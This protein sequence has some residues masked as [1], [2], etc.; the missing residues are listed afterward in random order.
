MRIIFLMIMFLIQFDCMAVERKSAQDDFTPLIFSCLNAYAKSGDVKDI[1][2][3]DR[4]YVVYVDNGKLID[5]FFS[6]GDVVEGEG[7]GD[8]KG[9]LSCSG[10]L[11]DGF[12][13]YRLRNPYVSDYFIDK[14]SVGNGVVNVDTCGA[15]KERMYIFESGKIFYQGEKIFEC[16]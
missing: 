7:K 14:P 6:H 16:H 8:Y 1:D 9:I 4:V 2:E 5:I 13:I 10:I 11:D 15:A 3:I 12:N